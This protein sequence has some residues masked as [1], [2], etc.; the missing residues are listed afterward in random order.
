[1][2]NSQ[3]KKYKIMRILNLINPEDSDIEFRISRFPDGQQNITLTGGKIDLDDGYFENQKDIE[4]L[5]SA[6][7]NSF[8]DLEIIIAA[9]ACLR[10]LQIERIHLGVPYF[11]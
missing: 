5:I 4:V 1:M 7:L 6:R 9:V 10:E 2:V 11:L 3:V 8:L